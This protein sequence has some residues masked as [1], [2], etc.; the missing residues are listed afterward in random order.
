MVKTQCYEPRSVNEYSEVTLRM[1]TGH[2]LITA[3]LKAE[4]SHPV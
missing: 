1:N 3:N 2:I 4:V